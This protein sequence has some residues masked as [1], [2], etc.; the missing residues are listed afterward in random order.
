[1]SEQ[2]VLAA[3]GNPGTDTPE[4]DL[5]WNHATGQPSEAGTEREWMNPQPRQSWFQEASKCGCNRLG[6]Q[7]GKPAAGL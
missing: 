4:R 2:S 1:M 3:W 7:S 5:A 6:P